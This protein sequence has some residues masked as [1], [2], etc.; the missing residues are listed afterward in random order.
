MVSISRRTKIGAAWSKTLAVL[1]TNGRMNRQARVPLRQPNEKAY[2]KN[3]GQMLK[4]A[5]EVQ[6]NASAG[7][8]RR[9]EVTGTSVRNN[10]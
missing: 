3:L 2:M 5:Q 10:A 1:Y 9:M 8:A 6:A 4:Q 7:C